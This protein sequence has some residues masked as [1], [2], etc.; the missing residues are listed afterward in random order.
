MIQTL[1]GK[2]GFSYA[3]VNGIRLHSPYDPHKEADRFIISKISTAPSKII[4]LGPG[5]GYII[6]SCKNFFPE[7]EVIAVYYHLDFFK[8]KDSFF[9][10]KHHLFKS[11]N[12]LALFLRNHLHDIDLEGLT[13]I[14]WPGSSRIFPKIS[15]EVNKVIRN[16]LLELH[17]NFLTTDSFGK[18]MILNS[19]K[20]FLFHQK[21]VHWKSFSAPIV[22]AAS[23]PSLEKSVEGLKNNR[24]KY[25]L[26]SLPS[27]LEMLHFHK[28]APDSVI[29]TDSG[30]YSRFHSYFF[31]NNF[32][33]AIPLVKAIS[34]GFL[35]ELTDNPTVFIGWKSFF[36]KSFLQYYYNGSNLIPENGTVAGTALEFISPSSPPSVFFAGLDFS[37]KDLLSHA[38][39]HPFYRLFLESVY[40]TGPFLDVLYSRHVS[41]M[42]HSNAFSTYSAWFSRKI[43][44]YNFPVYRICPS[45]VSINGCK[46]IS[47]PD[48]DSIMQSNPDLEISINF[49]AAGKCSFDERI[50]FSRLFVLSLIN[51]IDQAS[52]GGNHTFNS[53]YADQLLFEIV[54]TLN[55]IKTKELKKISRENVSAAE[56]IF[57][58]LLNEARTFF[59]AIEQ[60]IRKL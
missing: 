59:N 15:E 4:I 10:D 19:F 39:P 35:P 14:E 49:E 23:G 40:R 25:L 41:F 42:E 57:I 32:F 53:V 36:E 29:T 52:Q 55:P 44:S 2:N 13:V 16:I 30:Y 60:W 26:F 22:I 47:L 34:S 31:S 5:L 50:E 38:R 1:I 7:S 43:S 45:S 9:P 11:P 8:R 6:N 18:K 54:Y 33:S 46:D 56:D 21:V 20:N 37:Y 3:T 24:K 17:G 27:S 12:A 48:F 28:L 58:S 51:V